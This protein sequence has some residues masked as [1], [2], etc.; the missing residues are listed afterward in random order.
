MNHTRPLRQTLCVVLTTICIMSCSGCAKI[1]GLFTRPELKSYERIAVLGLDEEEEQIF[2][3]AY[4]KAFP[5]QMITFVE[6]KEL[7]TIM[8]E[9]DLLK[10]G[11]KEKEGY[12]GPRLND[13]T[14]ARIRQ[15]FG[16]E[17]LILCSYDNV[18]ARPTR[19][20]LRVRILDSETGAIVGSV[21][22]EG[23]NSFIYHSKATTTALRKNLKIEKNFPYVD[24][25]LSVPRP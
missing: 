10:E 14:R 18:G 24:R 3:A 5:E 21:I 22:S 6:R 2:M 15:I 1:S 8:D 25:R 16:V 19:K 7:D 11:R 20:K 9:Q 12:P 4:T 17:L 13:N 23:R